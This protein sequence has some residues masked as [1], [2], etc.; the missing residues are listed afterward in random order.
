MVK[1]R[2]PEWCNHQNPSH[3]PSC[4]SSSSPDQGDFKPGH[5][6]GM[7][8]VDGSFLTLDAIMDFPRHGHIPLK[9]QSM[10]TQESAGPTDIFP[11]HFVQEKRCGPLSSWEVE[12]QSCSPL[13]LQPLTPLRRVTDNLSHTIL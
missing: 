12:K 7:V 8:A 13:L 3:T 5:L 10:S 9:F 4:N 1:S 11:F 2:V 6:G